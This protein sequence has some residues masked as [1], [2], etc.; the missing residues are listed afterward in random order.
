MRDPSKYL[1]GV[2]GSYHTWN[3]IDVWRAAG[4]VELYHGPFSFTGLAGVEGIDF[5]ATS[6]GLVVTNADNSHFFGQFDLSYYPT[7][8]L[9]LTA[10]YDYVNETGMGTAGV[11]YLMNHGNN[12]ASLFAKARFGA[13]DYQSIT[14][15][16]KVYF[17]ADP[18]ASLITRHRDGRTG[19][20]HAGV[21]GPL[22]R[23]E[24]II[25]LGRA[26][27]ALPTRASRTVLATSSGVGQAMSVNVHDN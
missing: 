17:G 10:G 27:P 22:P 6:G 3:S 23:L 18:K 8:N 25:R 21:P 13:S 5:P 9:K 19:Q 24:V 26:R 20:L 7:E 2:Y 14:A 1:L 16:L 11:E 12:P 15:G 4:E